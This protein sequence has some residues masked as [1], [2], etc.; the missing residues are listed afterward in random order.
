VCTL[1]GHSDWVFSVAFSADG[2]RVVSGSRDN[3]VKIWDADKGSEVRN[4][5]ECTRWCDEFQ[6]F[7]DVCTRVLA[8]IW[9]ELSAIGRC[10]P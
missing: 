6:A 5:G 3:L 7:C 9:S 1:T 2:K 10:A 4:P 8:L